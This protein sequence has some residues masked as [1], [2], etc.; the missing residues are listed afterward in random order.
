MRIGVVPGSLEFAVKM[1]TRFGTA[2]GGRSPHELA[3]RAIAALALTVPA[4]EDSGSTLQSTA[5]VQAQT[6]TAGTTGTDAQVADLLVVADAG[7]GTDATVLAEISG[8]TDA[9]V[10]AEVSGGTDAT[11]LAEISGGT[12]AGA[13]SDVA[14]GG[15]AGGA[16]LC[17][18]TPNDGACCMHLGEWCQTQFPPEELDAI[19]YCQFGPN[20]DASTGCSPWGPPAPPRFEPAAW[21]LA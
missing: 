6:D 11:V 1:T 12:D 9:T 18:A 7:T 2:A 8:G 10:L 4:C 17:T 19:A 21:G 14:S 5:D 20:Y 15:D 13:G 16:P 3:L